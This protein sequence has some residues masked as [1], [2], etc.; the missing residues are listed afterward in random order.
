MVSF[1][2][3]LVLAHG[4]SLI[5]NLCGSVGST[6]DWWADECSQ[7][8]PLNKN[9]PVSDSQETIRVDLIEAIQVCE[10]LKLSKLHVK[11][12]DDRGRTIKEAQVTLL[13][14]SGWPDCEVP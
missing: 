4:A 10:T 12:I 7:Y 2:R 5:V 6:G 11:Q 14:F 9:E 3:D 8:W 13:H 1:W